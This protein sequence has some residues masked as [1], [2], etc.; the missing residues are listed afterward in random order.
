MSEQTQQVNLMTLTWQNNGGTMYIPKQI[1][2][3]CY[4]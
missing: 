4:I 3:L 2:I 1:Y